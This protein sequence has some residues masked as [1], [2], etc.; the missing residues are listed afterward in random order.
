MGANETP[1]GP[2]MNKDSGASKG[3]SR[4]K[5][6][7]RDVLKAIAAGTAAGA[8]GGLKGESAQ[9]ATGWRE[10]PE[11]FALNAS[12]FKHIAENPKACMEYVTAVEEV[13]KAMVSDAKFG[14]AV[15]EGVDSVML[16]NLFNENRGVLEP[17]LGRMDGRTVEGRYRKILHASELFENVSGFDRVGYESGSEEAI[18]FSSGVQSS[19][20]PASS[21]SSSS[22]APGGATNYG[23]CVFHYWGWIC[24]GSCSPCAARA[25]CPGESP[26]DQENRMD[27]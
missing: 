11:K 12:K 6:G 8:L 16:I 13:V 7:R 27:T 5:K 1:K 23:C 4:S 18:V 21:S 20:T 22:C 10:Q 17:V 26:R 15:L 24:G 25:C 19:A 14:S 2:E 3:N 9:G